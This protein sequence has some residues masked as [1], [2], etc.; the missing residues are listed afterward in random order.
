MDFLAFEIEIKC[1]ENS[2]RVVNHQGFCSSLLVYLDLIQIHCRHKTIY[3]QSIINLK[4]LKTF[5]FNRN[6]F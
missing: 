1:W 3:S 4:S 2:D 6:Y 5:D